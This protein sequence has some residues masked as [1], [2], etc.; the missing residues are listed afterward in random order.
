MST[1]II[2]TAFDTAETF[3]APFLFFVILDLDDDSTW[4]PIQRTLAPGTDYH[5]YEVYAKGT[6][7]SVKI[8]PLTQSQHDNWKHYDKSYSTDYNTLTL[9]WHDDTLARLH[10]ADELMELEIELSLRDSKQHEI[11]EAVSVILGNVAEYTLSS[12]AAQP[13]LA[14]RI[15]TQVTALK[16]QIN[17]VHKTRAAKVV[18]YN[19]FLHRLISAYAQGLGSGRHWNEVNKA[20]AKA[21]A[22]YAC[23]Q[24][25]TL[26][27]D[28]D[29]D[30]L[31]KPSAIWIDPRKRIVPKERLPHLTRR[32]AMRLSEIAVKQ[33][34]ADHDDSY[35]KQRGHL[36]GDYEPPPHIVFT[37]AG[38]T[39]LKAAIK[40]ADESRR[41]PAAPDAISSFRVA[42]SRITSSRPTAK[43]A[44][45]WELPNDGGSPIIGVDVEYVNAAPASSPT[46][47]R[48]AADA[49]THNITGLTAGTW[50]FRVRAVNALG[51]GDWA[52]LTE[53]I[54]AAN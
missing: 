4:R 6:P 11:L 51:E 1:P 31:M 9:T 19:E 2:I 15:N 29:D 22:C 5:L 49:T 3:T 48:L 10:D 14:Q 25:W 18:E 43:A 52:S 54:A 42:P 12:K 39:A 23:E 30:G 27:A 21:V 20:R 13:P 24:Y 41:D 35:W 45:V 34:A 40:E 28:T 46:R 26:G 37:D 17:D 50:I 44:L 8:Y 47:T 53:T 38:K 16:R 33:F 7:D 32:A 36:P